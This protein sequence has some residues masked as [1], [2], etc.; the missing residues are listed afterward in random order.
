MWVRSNLIL[1]FPP[2]RSARFQG[3]MIDL[4]GESLTMK[5]VAEKLTAAQAV[6]F[7]FAHYQKKTH[8]LAVSTRR[9]DESCQGQSRELQGRHCATRAWGVPLTS[10]DQWIAEHRDVYLDSAKN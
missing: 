4:A 3:R 7:Q 10:F 1:W 9:R 8:W 6:T 5:E 2:R